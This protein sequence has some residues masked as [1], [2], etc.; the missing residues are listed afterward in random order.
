MKTEAGKSSP[1]LRLLLTVLPMFVLVPT[2][3]CGGNSQQDLM[4]RAA[5]RPRDEP[6]DE[7]EDEV[8]STPPPASVADNK[9]VEQPAASAAPSNSPAAAIDT[10]GASGVGSTAAASGL[11]PIAA[12]A[13]TSGVSDGLLPPISERQPTAPLTDFQRRKMAAD[14]IKKIANG[15]N[16][17]FERKGSL[18][19][20]G[21]KSKSGIITL[22]WRVEL[23]PYLGYD[24]LYKQF[25][26]NQPWDSPKNM[27]LLER[28]P[29]CYVSPERFDTNTNYLGIQG[30]SY[31]F[32]DKPVP[33]RNIEDGLENTLAILEVNNELAVP[34][35]SPSD[36]DVEVGRAAEFI[37][38][39]RT[40]G[41]YA[42]WGNGWTT[43]R[44]VARLRVRCKTPALD[45]LYAA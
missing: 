2:S 10:T 8:D 23:L 15:L 41:T 43:P 33:V 5:Q 19:A 42:I 29:D 7:E 1:V 31:L 17:Y 16:V 12:D 27:A 38:G 21:M 34:W 24:E 3:G 30:V 4:M 22:S 26:P 44:P 11:K 20:R 14:N 13:A 36:F 25:D 9:P 40:E 32:Q 39:L 28:I 45:A 35:T 18:P 6:K 37:G